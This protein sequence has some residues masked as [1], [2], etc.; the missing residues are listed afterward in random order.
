MNTLLSDGRTMK[1]IDELYFDWMVQK[2]HGEHR[3]QL[4]SLLH[5]IAFTYQNP[6]D[7][8]RY[9]DGINLRYQF[10][11]EAS[12]SPSRI[13][14]ELDIRSCSVLEMM[15]ALAI[16]IEVHIMK[17]EDIGDRTSFWFDRMLDSLGLGWVTDDQFRRGYCVDV[18]YRFLN[19]DYKPNGQ[20]GLFTV[21]GK[22]DL[23][24]VDIWYQAMWYLS[25]NY[26]YK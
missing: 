16:R 6:M 20:G 14:R 1:S 2:C 12:Y 8:N 21:E 11:D 7:G 25:A 23:R 17:D 3:R 24:N 22:G 9:D 13:A 26:T 18:I 5:T 4:L 19:R 15:L 10:G